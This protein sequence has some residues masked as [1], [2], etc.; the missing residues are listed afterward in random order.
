MP[1]NAPM[2]HSRRHATPPPSTPAAV[3]ASSPRLSPE[4]AKA[5][6]DQIARKQQLALLDREVAKCERMVAVY[7]ADP[8]ATPEKRQGARNV[9]ALAKSAWARVA[10]GGR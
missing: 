9:L 1:V 2:L 3:R 8:T 5:L 4:A 7:D 10:N 6:L